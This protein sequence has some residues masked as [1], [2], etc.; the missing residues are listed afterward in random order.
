M[1]VNTVHS[2]LWL[3]PRTQISAS[4]VVIVL[5]SCNNILR[6][7]LVCLYLAPFDCEVQMIPERT[8]CTWGTAGNTS[9][10]HRTSTC[11]CR[12]GAP[13]S[14]SRSGKQRSPCYS[15]PEALLHFQKVQPFP[16]SCGLCFHL[17]ERN[18]WK[19]WHYYLQTWKVAE[20]IKET[21]LKII[22]NVNCSS[23]G[24]KR[25]STFMS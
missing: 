5:F 23:E 13:S 15:P 17:L 7:F 6:E 9:H 4:W 21:S 20:K 25:C 24:H 18:C 12:A 2:M 19:E 8:A 14:R 3:I 16:T 11:A 22:T 10:S 1:T